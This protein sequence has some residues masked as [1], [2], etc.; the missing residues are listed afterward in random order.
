MGQRSQ[1]YVRFTDKEGEKH[2]FARYYSWNYAERMVSRAKHSIEWIKEM[3]NYS[4]VF[5]TEPQRLLRILDVNFDMQDVVIS[6]DI[7]QEWKDDFS[8]ENFNN[9]VFKWQDNNDGK[10]FIDI[11]ENEST[12][13]YAFTDQYKMDRCMSAAQYMTWNHKE[14]RKSKYIDNEQ[15]AIC[16]KNIRLIPKLAKLMTKEELDEFINYDYGITAP[17][18][19]IN[20]DVPIYNIYDGN[21]LIFVTEDEDQA[22]KMCNNINNDGGSGYYTIQ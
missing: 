2:L 11:D 4:Y 7:V 18:K 13:K 8:E 19:E 15:K 20:Y 21:E 3:L 6:Q 9:F 16:E 10:L 17:A 5:T 12:I 22:F 1:I 14:W